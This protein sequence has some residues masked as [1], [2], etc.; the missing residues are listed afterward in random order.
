MARAVGRG[1]RLTDF[2]PPRGTQDLLPP[3]SD[4]IESLAADAAELA[5]RFGFRPVESP[6]FEHTELFARG[7][8]EASDIVTKE[9][10]TFED[11]GGRSLTLKPESTAPSNTIRLRPSRLAWNRCRSA[12]GR[13]AGSTQRCVNVPLWPT[14]VAQC[15]PRP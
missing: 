11:K 7:V 15:R 1:A 9:M 12:R 14:G 4:A 10:Y 2:Q 8:G 5:R 13:G 6:T 3:T